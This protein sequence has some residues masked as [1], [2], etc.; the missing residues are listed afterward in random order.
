MLVSRNTSHKTE[1]NT[2]LLSVSTVLICYRK[3]YKMLYDKHLR[4]LRSGH[5]QMN[6]HHRNEL[7]C[8]QKCALKQ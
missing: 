8:K 5:F 6:D 7:K 1:K 3:E 4:A 2:K